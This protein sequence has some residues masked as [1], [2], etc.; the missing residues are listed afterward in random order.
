MNYQMKN[1]K[2]EVV[3][4]SIGA[5]LQSITK[6]NTEYL[7]DGNE[8][9]WADRSPLLFPFVGRLTNQKYLL[10]GVEYSMGIHGFARRLDYKVIQQEDDSII[11][12]ATDTEET[13]VAYPYHF[14]LRVSYRLVEDTIQIGYSVKN[15]SDSVMYFGIGGHPGFQVPLEDGLTFDDYYLEFS[16]P[17]QPDRIGHTP[18][19]YLNGRNAEF[20]LEEGK[21]LRL[22][23]DMFD[24]DAIVLQNMAREVC[25]KS[26][27][28]TRQ[29]R[30]SYPQCSY[31]GLWHAPKTDAPYI[32][33]EP[34]TS[35]A[36]RQDVVE[37]LAN[38]SDM[39]HLKP[40]KEYKNEWSIAIQ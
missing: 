40:N 13:Y 10:N 7:W 14:V 22:S 32:C 2:L 24:D 21:R 17:A 19:C 37:E 34:W 1:K 33:I 16:L 25:L 38:K 28:G 30:V 23:H 20:A 4:S 39:I 27:K 12:E 26:D 36:S 6:D 9:Y 29:V 31:L 3:V 15:T 18:T 5:E 35:L 11:L 8:T